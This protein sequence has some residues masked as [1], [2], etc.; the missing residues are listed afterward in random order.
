M[1]VPEQTCG[2]KVS[3][4]VA[5]AIRK[6]VC[7]RV[8]VARKEQSA[9][10]PRNHE[11]GIRLDRNTKCK[12]L[13]DWEDGPCPCKKS[14]GQRPSSQMPCRGI[15]ALSHSLWESTR[16]PADLDGLHPPTSMPPSNRWFSVKDNYLSGRTKRGP[17]GIEKTYQTPAPN[18][19]AP[20]TPT[21]SRPSR[22]FPTPLPRTKRKP[23]FYG[24]FK[25]VE[26]EGLEPTTR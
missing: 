3:A 13:Y 21:P 15:S 17:E 11:H 10:L 19:L 23:R 26:A 8:R 25:M 20:T 18:R 7:A 12:P 1:A 9:A 2:H 6:S 5:W 24:V 22:F 4:T 16:S 14:H